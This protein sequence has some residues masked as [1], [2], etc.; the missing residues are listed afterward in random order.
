[1]DAECARPFQRTG[2]KHPDLKTF[3]WERRAELLGSLLT[4]SRAWYAAGCPRPQITLLGG[5]E[6]WTFTIGGIL[7]HATVLGFLA[8][9]EELYEQADRESQQWESFLLTLNEIYHGNTFRVSELVNTLTRSNDGLR[10]SLPDFIAEVLVMAGVDLY[11]VK[12]LL[13]HHDFKMTQRYAHLSPGHL[14]AAVG[15]LDVE[16]TPEVTPAKASNS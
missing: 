7:E 16:V 5:F 10:E 11:S 15:V 13:G 9:G 1:M 3:V 4:L 6:E 12:E 8:N 14:K 2:F